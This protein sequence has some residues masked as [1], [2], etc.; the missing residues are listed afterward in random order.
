MEDEFIVQFYDTDGGQS[1]ILEVY[2]MNGSKILTNGFDTRHGKN[3]RTVQMPDLNLNNGIY[4]IEL[5][6]E[7]GASHHAKVSRLAKE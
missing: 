4:I 6:L 3:I 7:N 1:A 2:D 5:K